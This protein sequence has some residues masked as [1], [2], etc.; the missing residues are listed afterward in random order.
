MILFLPH[1]YKMSA[2]GTKKPGSDVIQQLTF[3]A[4]YSDL[5]AMEHEPLAYYPDPAKRPEALP[6]GH[7]LQAFYHE[8]KRQEANRRA[9][10]GVKDTA[11]AKWRYLHSH[12]GYYDI[13]KPVLSQRRFAN[14]SLGNQSDIYSARPE[15]AYTGHSMD[16]M[17]R[18][19][20]SGGVLYTAEAQ[21]WGRNK[22]RDRVGQLNAI[23]VAQ[24]G[25]TT[26]EALRS[27]P[28]PIPVDESVLPDS[29]STKAKIELIATLDG[30]ANA[31]E[32]STLGSISY[33]DVV[34]FLRL[35]FR[36][37]ATADV[38]ELKEILEYVD[39]IERALLGIA[40]QMDESGDATELGKKWNAFT[41]ST[42][43]TFVKVREYLVRM[44]GISNKSP[45][46]R[47]AASATFIK[48]LGFT[49][50][51]GKAPV[52]VEN[53]LASAARRQDAF[54][55]GLPAQA[56]NP[57]DDNVFTSPRSTARRA[58]FDPS[59][60]DRMG[61]NNGAYFG[62]SLPEGSDAAM[63]V[64]NTFRDMPEAELQPA[65]VE[66]GLEEEGKE[67]EGVRPEALPPPRA[68]ARFTRPEW[69]T[70]ES[71]PR[72]DREIRRLLQR[73]NEEGHGLYI[74]RDDTPYTVI[75][76]RIIQLWKVPYEG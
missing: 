62:E 29:V 67:E 44:I 45:A 6:V 11:M 40:S 28:L 20:L 16:S 64:R 41:Q 73:L 26:G 23:D 46:E 13:P 31:I 48:S 42:Y 55:T 38:E 21:R 66:R 53:M 69:L 22:L 19:R 27:M 3:P 49:T 9:L 14:P 70:R 15:S 33:T 57:A 2:Y 17:Y 59:V 72:N 47:K 43:D 75:R 35:L 58:R 7:D 39:Y 68:V 65:V 8:Q 54:D 37:A 1:K 60:R 56:F 63:G 30:I 74:P 61:A 52:E 18:P 76:K 71:I 12:A 24:M 5:Y 34:K 50:R 32:T 10:N 4:L 25:F 36:Y 51:F